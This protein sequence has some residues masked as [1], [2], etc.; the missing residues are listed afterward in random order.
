MVNFISE[1]RLGNYL[2]SAAC[3]IGYARKHNLPYTFSGQFESLF[4]NCINSDYYKLPKR[5]YIVNLYEKHFGYEELLFNEDWRE[6]N[7]IIHGYRQSW[8]YFDHCKEEVIEAFNIKPVIRDGWVSI[9]VRRGDYLTKPDYHPVITMDYL[10]R[11]ISIFTSTG[12]RKFMVF[13]DDPDW[14]HENI[15]PDNFPDCTFE[16]SEGRTAMEDMALM[17]GCEHN[18]IANSSFSWWAAYLNRNPAKIILAPEKWFGKDG[19]IN[20]NDLIPESWIKL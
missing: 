9:H 4:P 16:Y 6:N 5:G 10:Q 11:A 2:F 13:G 1:G 7:I 20:T 17:A 19:P 8:K 3:C 14:N 12:Y 15:N 18:I